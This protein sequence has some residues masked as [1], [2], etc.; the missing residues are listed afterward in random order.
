MSS[1]QKT[2][3]VTGASQ[4]IGAGIVK[5]FVERGFNVVANSRKVT[6]STEVAASDHVAL[7]DGD[8]GQPAT[9]AR[10]I[11]T[12]LS[13]FQAVD[14]LVNNA[15]IFFTKPFTE[16]TA[17]DF[18]SLVSTN[19]EGFLYITQLA[20]KQMLAQKTG[21]SI[22]TITAALARNPLRGVPAAGP[23]VTKG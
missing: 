9:A 7:V 22:V 1:V 19:L 4:G 21:G 12:A 17:D 14:V 13:R 23:L 15:G 11:E 6:Q 20:V 8:I 10:V 3:I 5:G 16:Y 18:K 2:A